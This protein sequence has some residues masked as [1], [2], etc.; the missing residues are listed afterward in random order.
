MK[1]A[2]SQLSIKSSKRKVIRTMGV[3]QSGWWT[4][5]QQDLVLVELIAKQLIIID[6]RADA[7]LIG[8]K[9]APRH[10]EPIRGR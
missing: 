8:N 1:A 4:P 9:A 5:E 7:K 10:I 3:G 6:Y 2:R